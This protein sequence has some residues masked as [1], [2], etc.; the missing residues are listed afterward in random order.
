MTAKNPQFL[1][2]VIPAQAGIHLKKMAIIL[3]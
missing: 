3:R 1:N 2:A